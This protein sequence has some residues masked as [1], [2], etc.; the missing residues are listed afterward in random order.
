MKKQIVAGA[1]GMILTA[2]VCG[3]IRTNIKAAASAASPVDAR[4][5]MAKA[6]APRTLTCLQ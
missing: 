1:V 5:E 2:M 3:Q 6:M 4:I